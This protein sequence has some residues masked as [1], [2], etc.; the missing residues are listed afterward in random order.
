MSKLPYQPL[1]QDPEVNPA[2]WPY[3]STLNIYP[4]GPNGGSRMPDASLPNCT[5]YC[6]G[7]MLEA[8]GSGFNARGNWG[9]ACNWYSRAPASYRI[10]LRAVPGAVA[11]FGPTS[12][13]SAGHVMFVEEVFSNGTWKYTESGWSRRGSGFTIQT[14]TIGNGGSGQWLGCLL[15]P[16]PDFLPAGLINYYSFTSTVNSIVIPKKEW[17][18]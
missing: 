11:V 1:Y 12:N 5:S 10:G 8:W 15:C 18:V 7:K 17:R 2:R 6:Y 16:N 4:A 9:N 13:N 14:R 3:F